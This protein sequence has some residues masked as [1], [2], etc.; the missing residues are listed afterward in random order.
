MSIATAS[1]T[2]KPLPGV[3][4]PTQPLGHIPLFASLDAAEQQALFASMQIENYEPHKA[5]FWMGDKGGTF[6]VINQGEVTVSVPNEQG[7]HVTLAV[8]GPGGFFGEG[9]LLDGGTRTATVR[10]NKQTELYSLSR[11]DFHAFLRRRPEGAIRVLTV[12][13]ERQR[14]S[15]KVFRTLKNPNAVYAATQANATAWERFSDSIARIAAGRAFMAFHVA[16]FGG[17]IICNALAGLHALPEKF[18]F[19]PF[20]FGLLTLIVSLE[21]IFLS[22][23]VMISQNRQSEKERL[24]NDL[25]YQ[26]NLKAQTEIMG[27]HEKLDRLS[28]MIQSTQADNL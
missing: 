12:M 22:I 6:Y 4:T 18:A 20:P 19:D 11:Q 1:P 28:A 3:A 23:F 7:E 10:T 16:W 21:A 15:A 24:R 14:E 17:W 5:V 13:G 27:L 9:S 26:V 25:D 8:L 2:P